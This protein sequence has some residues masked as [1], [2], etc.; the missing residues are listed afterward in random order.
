MKKILIAFVVFLI[1][2]IAYPQSNFRKGYVIQL[3][4]DTI[5]GSI[6]YNDGTGGKFCQFKVSQT[7][8]PVIYTP[9]EI[10]GYGFPGDKF[11]VS[12]KINQKDGFSV[13]VFIELLIKGNVSLYKFEKDFYI[14]KSDSILYKLSNESKETEIDG[15]IVSLQTNRYLGVLNF[16]LSDCPEIVSMIHK[17]TFSDRSLTDLIVEYNRR[18][19]SSSLIY[20][21]SKPWFHTSV[22]LA[23]SFNFSRISM[24]TSSSI[25]GKLKSSFRT[26]PSF[27]ISVDLSSP[28]LTERISFHGEVLYS[29]SIYYLHNLKSYYD[30]DILNFIN[31]E[32]HQ[33]KI[34]LGARY[35]FPG[36]KAT[37]FLDFDITG[38]F[39]LRAKSNWKQEVVSNNKTEIVLDGPL[40]LGNPQLGIMGGAGVI[41]DLNN[42]ISGFFE[43]RFERTDGLIKNQIVSQSVFN[44]KV[45]NIQLVIGI[46]SR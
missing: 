27:G 15:K 41:K 3:D 34:P 5:Y 16:L 32:L 8:N 12:R 33:L 20:K 25:L 36:T 37:P 6:N 1:F 46:L 23:G 31:I 39:H 9:F 28:R 26:S 2:Q 11:Y 19:N 45:T 43:C 29:N 42:K 17:T 35:T 7:Q 10:S 30:E 24:M 38:T 4:H 18:M 22:G 14:E 44:S 13:R 40:P 21:A